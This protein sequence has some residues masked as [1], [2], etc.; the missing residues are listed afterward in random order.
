MPTNFQPP[1]LPE[2]KSRTAQLWIWITVGII[3]LALIVVAIVKGVQSMTQAFEEAM[4]SSYA[5]ISTGPTTLESLQQQVSYPLTVKEG[6]EFDLVLTIRNP[7]P[8]TLDLESID[9]LLDGFDIIKSPADTTHDGAQEWAITTSLSTGTTLTKT[10]RLQ[11][12][13][14]GI[15]TGDIDLY[16]S[17][18]SPETDTVTIEVIAP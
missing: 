9:I 16:H 10:F 7:N 6:E 2:K 13:T 12:Q 15:W 5:G 8:T 17:G 3:A 4:I 1:P 11:A 14:I 18:D